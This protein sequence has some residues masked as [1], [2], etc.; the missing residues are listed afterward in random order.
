MVNAGLAAWAGFPNTLEYE[1]EHLVNVFTD[2]TVRPFDALDTH[3]L[4]AV[5]QEMIQML[6]VHIDPV[7]IPLFPIGENLP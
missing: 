4:N 3:V 5:I 7:E 6:Q 1:T 2:L